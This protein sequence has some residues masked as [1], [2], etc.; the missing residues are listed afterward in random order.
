[1]KTKNKILS[2]MLVIF[3]L[4]VNSLTAC[5]QYPNT[6][7]EDRMAD[8]ETET[9]QGRETSNPEDAEAYSESAKNPEKHKDDGSEKERNVSDAPPTVDEKAVLLAGTY[10]EKESASVLRVQVSEEA[11]PQIP[12]SIETE[13]PQPENIIEI[14]YNESEDEIPDD[15][16]PAQQTV[17]DMEEPQPAEQ[18]QET[19]TIEK[20]PPSHSHAYSSNTI[21][22]TCATAG[23]TQYTCACGDSYITDEVAALGHEWQTYS[24][25]MLTGQQAHE[26]CGDCGADLTANGIS[27]A[28][29]AQHAKQHVMADEGAT[30]RTYTTMIDTYSE[31][32]TCKCSR[33]GEIQ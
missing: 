19:E 11:K 27:G 10:P 23:Y 29:I 26:I 33:C 14:L 20:Q 22:P 2:L 25:K 32:I 21:P 13:V 18:Y 15:W 28:A 12:V 31:V 30:G 4:G 17:P 16:Y 24:E 9:A 6:Q 8:T 7:A 3:M 1:M 5:G